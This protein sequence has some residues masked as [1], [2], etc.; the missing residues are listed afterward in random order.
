MK[1]V[2]LITVMSVSGSPLIPDIKLIRDMAETHKAHL[3][4]ILFFRHP[5]IENDMAVH[6]FWDTFRS[7]P[8]GSDFGQELI[9]L[10]KE[11]GLVNH[12]VWIEDNSGNKEDAGN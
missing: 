3:E 4:N 2:E 12:S 11:Y 6:L 10:L 9:Q 1:W 8:A 5:L 7:E